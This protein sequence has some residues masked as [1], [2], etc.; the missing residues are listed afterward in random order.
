MKKNHYRVQILFTFLVYL[1]SEHDMGG[2]LGTRTVQA[3]G[4]SCVSLH[5][6]GLLGSGHILPN[7]FW[8]AAGKKNG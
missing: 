1:M 7:P 2:I 4:D 5:S 3:R 6:F 8:F